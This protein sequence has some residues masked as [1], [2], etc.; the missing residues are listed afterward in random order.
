VK[1]MVVS[2]WLDRY[3]GDSRARALPS[4]SAI[5]LAALCPPHIDVAVAHEHV[6]PVDPYLVDADVA[7]ITAMTGA[8]PR[9]YEL[10]DALRARGIT[11]LLG[12]PHA[13]LLPME[14][15][16]H[17]DAVAV[18]EAERTFAT[19]LADVEHGRLQRFY[20][21]PS[22]IPL[23]GL[24][25]PR[26]DLLEE[27]FTFRC[28]VQA[29]RGCPFGCGFCTLKALDNRFRVRPVDD[30]IRDISAGDGRTWLQRKFVWFWDDNLTGNRAYARELC[31]RLRPLRKWW[32]TQCSIDTASDAELLRLMARSGCLAVFVGVESFSAANLLQVGKRHNRVEQYR[33]AIAAFHRVGIAVHAGMIVGMDDDTERSIHALPDAVDALGIDLPFL[34]V[35]TPFPATPLRQ[36]LAAEGRLLQASWNRHNG[37]A[38]TFEPRHMTPQTLEAAYWSAREAMYSVRRTLR[39]ALGAGRRV[40]PAA[41]LLNGYVNA[42]LMSQNALCADRPWPGAEDRFNSP[43]RL[44]AD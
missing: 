11:V 36:Q 30:V 17:A 42:M 44:T 34:N 5:H 40:C 26:Y 14:A 4:L 25:V 13:S 15:A 21:Q 10:A 19:M 18:G 3:D 27:E 16:G 8:A 41:F 24:P 29:T 20:E 43:S 9:M 6:R 32:W 38:V 23:A 31:R 28:F 39:R 1:L 35:L 7:A 37:T 2:A 33:D 12:G 22:G